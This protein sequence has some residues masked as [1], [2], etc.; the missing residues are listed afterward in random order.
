MKI[1]LIN[2]HGSPAGGAEVMT[3]TLSKE[4]IAR[5]HEVRIFSSTAMAIPGLSFADY[6]CF[7]TDNPKL[8]MLTQVLNPSAYERLRGVLKEFHPDVVHIRMFLWQLSPLILPLLKRFPTVYHVVTYKPVCPTGRKLLPCGTACRVDQGLNCFKNK[9]LSLP[10]LGVSMMQH[11]FWSKWKKTIDTIIANSHFV[12]GELKKAG[13]ENVEVIWN[14]VPVRPMR[15]PLSKKPLAVYAGRLSGE[16]GVDILIR[17]F[18]IVRRKVPEAELLIAGEGAGKKQLLQLCDRLKL[19]HSV[20]FL[21]HL[22]REDME[23]RFESAWVQVVPSKWPEPFGIVATEGMMRGTAIVGSNTGGLAEIIQHEKTG[24][25]V[26]PFDCQGLAEK[27]TLLLTDRDLAEQ[28]GRQGRSFALEYF[29][30]E[31]YTNQILNLYAQA[32]KRNEPKNLR[33]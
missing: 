21:G 3:F 13:M 11:Y 26:A 19:N 25:Q 16:K 15:P 32:V 30:T 5:G 27:L 14:G 20:H 23:K 1:L 4:L 7:G 29:T 31:V 10:A 2:D 33:E 17:A 22:S 6:Y 9:C 24:F 28:M 8:R 12:A 18:E